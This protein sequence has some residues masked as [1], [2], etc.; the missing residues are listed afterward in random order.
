MC[1]VDKQEISDAQKY[2]KSSVESGIQIG[3]C[4]GDCGSVC[5]ND[6]GHGVSRGMQR[7][8]VLGLWPFMNISVCLSSFTSIHVLNNSTYPGL[9]G[10]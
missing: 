9:A 3:C 10:S 7:V 5:R 6:V 2:Q 4:R 1:L 8:A